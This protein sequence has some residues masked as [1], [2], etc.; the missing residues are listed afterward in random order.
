MNEEKNLLEENTGALQHPDYKN[1]I[2][3][4]LRSNLAPAKLCGRM[5]DYHEKDIA[6]A[7]ELLAREERV[8]LYKLLPDDLLARVLEYAGRKD[9]FLGELSVRRQ[10]EILQRFDTDE[11]A[12]YLRGLEKTRRALLIDL[13]E[14]ET[15]RE[16]A[17]ASAFDEEEIGSQ[18]TTDFI[19]IPQ[20][21][22]VRQA[23]RA[24]VEQAEDRDNLSTIYVLEKDGV[25]GGAIDLKDLIRARESTPLEDIVMASYPYVYAGE[26]VDACLE[27]LRGYS[28]DSIPVLDEK[29]RLRGVLTAQKIGELAGDALE[30]DYAKLGGLTAEED[31]QEP[32]LRSVRKRLPWLIALLG[33]GL[34]VSTVVGMFE[35]VVASVALVVCFQSLVLDMAGNVGTQSLAVTIRVLMDDSVEPRQKLR[36]I[37]KE[38]RIGL[39]N[40]AIL[41]MMAFV[42]IGGY[43]YLLKGQDLLL[44]FSVSACTGVALLL[45]M[46]ISSLAG[47]VIPMFFKKIHVDPAVASGP[48]ITTINDLV[49]V[50][51]YYGLAWLLLMQVLHIG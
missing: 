36:L 15:R 28:E 11:M 33:L 39:T 1:E 48:L 29:N 50:V 18:M 34:V 9:A 6:A 17:F 7:L 10:A 23:M 27:R 31:L 5:G 13:M 45:S 12:Q 49:A 40:G 22:T 30:D 4:I 51:S 25:L 35:A 21:L 2:A 14:D 19:A 16:L 8:R 3:A 20:G 47:T 43:L 38:A 41:G 42:A 24:L 37:G 46:V 32:V 44:A 26:T